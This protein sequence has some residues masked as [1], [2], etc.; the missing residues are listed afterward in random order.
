VHVDGLARQFWN[1]EL[2]ASVP[3]TTT[4][5]NAGESNSSAPRKSAVAPAPLLIVDTFPAPEWER[6]RTL[7]CESIGASLVFAS[8]LPIKM[9]R[10]L[11]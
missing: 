9:H 4:E 11:V 5:L 3:A 2:S 1:S 7:P 6:R 8:N 10:S